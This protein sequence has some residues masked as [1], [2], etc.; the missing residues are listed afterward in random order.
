MSAIDGDALF[1]AS[2]QRLQI[3]HIRTQHRTRPTNQAQSK[4]NFLAEERVI[5]TH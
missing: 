1:D 5:S 3:C 4:L 2:M